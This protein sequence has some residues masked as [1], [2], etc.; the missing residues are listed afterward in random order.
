MALLELLGASIL[1]A[2]GLLVLFML[3]NAKIGNKQTIP[4][5][6]IG[7]LAFFGGGFIVVSVVGLMVLIKKMVA[8]IIFAVGIFMVIGFPSNQSEQ[9]RGFSHFGIFLGLFFLFL[10]LFFLLF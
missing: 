6:I 2:F 7:L 10:G 5:L 8:L 1:M 3:F 4:V 9:K